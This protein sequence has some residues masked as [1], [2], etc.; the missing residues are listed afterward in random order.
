M[1]EARILITQEGLKNL[2]QLDGDISGKKIIITDCE[3]LN[4]KELVI[5]VVTTD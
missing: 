1:K 4:G 5:N 2:L 3:K